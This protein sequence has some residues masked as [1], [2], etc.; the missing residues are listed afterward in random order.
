MNINVGGGSNVKRHLFSP[1]HLKLALFIICLE[2]SNSF[3]KVR[4]SFQNVSLEINRGIYDLKN[5]KTNRKRYWN[6]TKFS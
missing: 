6:I 5:K 3:E 1:L 4:L 2:K